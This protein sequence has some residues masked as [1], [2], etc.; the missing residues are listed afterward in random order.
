MLKSG[1]QVEEFG[2]SSVKTVIIDV[3]NHVPAAQPTME[4]SEGIL[5]FQGINFERACVELTSRADEF[6]AI[7]NTQEQLGK[8]YEVMISSRGL[9]NKVLGWW[10]LS[11]LRAG[12]F[13]EQIL[14]GTLFQSHYPEGVDLKD[15]EV[16]R[17][18]V[19]REIN[20]CIRKIGTRIVRVNDHE[21]AED[22]FAP[23]DMPL[24]LLRGK[25]YLPPVV[26]LDEI[27]R[28]LCQQYDRLVG[29][30]SFQDGNEDYLRAIVYFQLVGRFLI[31][32]KMDVNTRAARGKLYLD[33][34]KRN[35]TTSAQSGVKEILP[36]E[37]ELSELPFLDRNVLQI[38]GE[39][40]L[41]KILEKSGLPLLDKSEI[42][43]FYEDKDKYRDYM[44]KL[45]DILLRI[46]DRDPEQVIPY[47][48]DEGVEV[49]KAL[50]SKLG[51]LEDGGECYR[52]YKL[53][54]REALVNKE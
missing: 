45:S 40:M 43:G 37:L 48:L 5:I 47:Y 18:K 8:I 16:I 23:V 52:K 6:N 21:F 9:L 4:T 28:K 22:V 7:K 50:L 35:L 29:E 26:K 24:Q 36:Q 41:I 13:Q 39:G 12:A 51:I 31:H 33:L 25:R 20:V 14:N 46:V 54:M 19:E 34:K 30:S 27:V 53:R 3:K 32:E 1:Q 11:N 2:G 38:V 10:R 42:K 44:E 15:A 17:S 49:L